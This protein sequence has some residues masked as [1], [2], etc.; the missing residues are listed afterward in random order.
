MDALLTGFPDATNP[1][2]A[3]DQPTRRPWLVAHELGRTYRIGT[4]PIEALADV[5]L[6]VCP[7]E[8]VALVGHS[9]SGKTTL[10]G[11]LGGLDRPTA[12]SVEVDGQCMSGWSSGQLA[13]YRR[14]T[15]GFLFQW[16]RLI[17]HLTAAE[18]VALPLVFAG[19]PGG[20][21]RERA[22]EL[23]AKVGLEARA[24]H[25]PAQLSGGEQQRVALARALASSPR[26]LLADEPTGSLD[27]STAEEVE[28]WLFQ[29][30]AIEGLTL[31]VGTHDLDLAARCDRRI[32][33]DHGRVVEE[34][35]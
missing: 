4:Q 11:L 32:R 12:G 6:E 23:L 29:L 25:R 18:N 5:S 26:L 21:R 13:L 3:H 33:L 14:T 17:G 31:V 2:D 1:T 22:V 27:R 24:Q 34:P 19:I 30:S 16:A 7:G 9:G 20:S 15:V 28:D 8:R 35:S 10:L